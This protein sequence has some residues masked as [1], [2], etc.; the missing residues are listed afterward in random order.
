MPEQRDAITGQGIAPH[1]ARSV[2][3]HSVALRPR[4]VVLESRVVGCLGRS[5][6]RNEEQRGNHRQKPTHDRGFCSD[7]A[8]PAAVTLLASSLAHGLE[9]P[10]TLV[11]A[12]GYRVIGRVSRKAHHTILSE[13]SLGALIPTRRGATPQRLAR[14]L[15]QVRAVC[16]GLRLGL[17]TSTN[18][19]EK[20]AKLSLLSHLGNE[21]NGQREKELGPFC[22]CLNLPLSRRH[23]ISY[24]TQERVDLG[25]LWLLEVPT[26]GAD[27]VPPMSVKG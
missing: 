24:C 26:D 21:W 23:G 4:T 22:N 8:K 13:R 15:R 18:L 9:S 7:R 27:H 10:S 2:C 11:K 5:R 3:F 25:C 17:S 6:A 14:G 20:P 19:P 12:G 1:W 16:V